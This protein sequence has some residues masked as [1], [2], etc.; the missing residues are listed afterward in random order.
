LDKFFPEEQGA[1]NFFRAPELF[2]PQDRTVKYSP[3]PIHMAVYRRPAGDAPDHSV[4]AQPI[5][6]TA[7]KAQRDAA[8]WTSAAR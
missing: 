1:A 2:D 4:N 6:I 8:G 5:S 7:A 3:A